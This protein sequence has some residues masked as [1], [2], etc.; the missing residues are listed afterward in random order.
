MTK[1]TVQQYA[2]KLNTSV[3]SIYRQINKGSLTSVKE[4]GKTL[5]LVEDIEVKQE[6]NTTVTNEWKELALRLEKKLEKANKEIRR[7]NKKLGKE[8][9]NTATTYLRYIN[10]IEKNQLILHPKEDEIIEAEPIKKK[11]KKSKK[12]GKTK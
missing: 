4:N 6:I 9:K 5:V 1:L 11:K 8:K 3:T 2:N 12:G 10:Q 7:L